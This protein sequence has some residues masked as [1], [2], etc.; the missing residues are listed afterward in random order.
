M[1][2]LLPNHDET[3]QFLQAWHP[4]G[5][6]CLSAI[7]P[8]ERA[9]KD[10]YIRSRIFHPDEE[11]AVR[12]W[13]TE[14]GDRNLYY[15]ANVAKPK[16]QWAPKNNNRPDRSD[17][18]FMVCLH[19][20]IDPRAGEDVA[21]EQDRI[22][23]LIRSKNPKDLPS[24]SV[25]VF[26]G[27]G[28]QVLWRLAEPVPIRDVAHAEDLARYNL[29]V[30][31][32]L[33]GDSAQDLSR[34]LRLPGTIN[35]PNKLKREKKGRVPSL[36]RIVEF[37]TD[38][39]YELR[40]FIQAPEI[41]TAETS[42]ARSGGAAKPS[43]RR[44]VEV[45]GNVQRIQDVNTELPET[46][47]GVVK[48][49]I[50]QG[51]NP[52]DFAQFNGDRSRAVWYVVC[53][54]VRQNVPDETIFSIV[55]DPA[56]GISAH[57]LDQPRPEKY[58]LR[59]IERAHEHAI[60]PDLRAFN[61][62]FAVITNF[63][64]RC[65]V[66]EEVYDHGLRRG[67]LSTLSFDDLRNAFLQ[68]RK[69][70][71]DKEKMPLAEWWL[72]HPQRR[73]YDRVVFRP[74]EDEYV[75]GC[76]NLWRG[77]AVEPIPGDCSLFLRHVRETLC[78]NDEDNY[79]YLLRWMARAVQFPGEPGQVAIVL[80]GRMGT[81]KSFFAKTFGRL[82]GRHYLAVSDSKRLVSNFNSH[83]RDCVVLFAD[84]AFYAGDKK[85]ESILKA[86]ITEEMLAI[87]AKGKDIEM[88]ASCLHVIMSSNEDWAVPAAMDDRRFFILQV[89]DEH[90][91]AHAHF[92]AIQ[93]QMEDGGYSALL[94]M[95]M[96]MDLTTFN[97]RARPETQ[98]LENE[99]LM[100]LGPIEAYWYECLRAGS[101]QLQGD[102]TGGWPERVA[103]VLVYDEVRRRLP[104]GARMSNVAIGILFCSKLLPPEASAK[105]VRI[106][107]TVIWRDWRGDDRQARNTPAFDLP[108][109]EVCR[110]WWSKR[111]GMTSEPWPTESQQTVNEK[112]PF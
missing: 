42:A 81:G 52:D 27:G 51:D 15:T 74:M 87:E 43:R 23:R 22:E 96:T 67:T 18:A 106:P 111:F 105:D 108:S 31:N 50:V 75:D 3:I 24:P 93:K 29:Q 57:V 69:E 99:K 13:L 88:G 10:D 8:D 86:L 47:P 55:T 101:L 73:Q 102:S 61:D 72:R 91:N 44:T 45:S 59:Q 54:L 103:R 76:Y 107:G 68:H 20:D 56:F 84:E 58:A 62:R 19:A 37:H 110:K 78:G 11:S 64:G 26:T 7:H 94:H 70:L 4:D 34:I 9:K 25:I 60:D 40:Q 38:R 28:Y 32:L 90:R 95:L 71:S 36:A 41:Q 21:Q 46:V 2:Q 12:A 82:F 6:W 16:D 5:P 79:L 104:Q 109:L 77:F 17:L 98:A 89:A 100:S 66:V 85:H 97:V 14:N 63:G 39:V 112:A 92:A 49:I 65:R 48:V 30:R 80:K 35:W 33:D 83:L 1:T 53:E